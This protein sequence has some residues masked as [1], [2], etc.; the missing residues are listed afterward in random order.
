VGD[1][2]R[3]NLCTTAGMRWLIG[4]GRT[5]S[6]A[7]ALCDVGHDV[8]A[9]PSRIA[10][11]FWR[12]SRREA[13]GHCALAAT[14]MWTFALAV[15]ATP[16]DRT[17]ANG[18]KGADFIQ[19][20]TQGRIVLDREAWR[21]SDPRGLYERQVALVPASAAD[22][23]LPV[24]PPQASV[25]FQPFAAVPYLWAA[26]LWAGIVI[27]VYAGVVWRASKALRRHMADNRLVLIG[28]TAFSPF[29]SLVLHGQTTPFP[30]C[31]FFGAWLALEARRPFIAGLCLSLLSVK[32]QFGLLLPVLAVTGRNG[33]LIASG[34]SM[35]IVL[36]GVMTAWVLGI[37][38]LLKY[39]SV[40]KQ[41]RTYGSLLEPNP[42][43]THSLATLTKLLPSPLSDGLWVVLVAVLA[44]V[45]WWIWRSEGATRV[46]V[47]ALIVI[48]VLA[49]P[50]LFAYDATVLALPIIW[51]CEWTVVHHSE[52]SDRVG[53]LTYGLCFFL[54]VP[55][56]V[57]I[58]V[59]ISVVFIVWLLIELTRACRTPPLHV[60]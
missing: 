11:P 60:S 19:L 35:G 3:H 41:F 10:P 15:Y 34:A 22:R 50:H 5:T 26:A 36:Q 20:Y 16:G 58:G 29:W 46:K 57:L 59:Q 53:A 30:L 48:A 27:A 49:N 13:Y 9:P 6:G 43:Q 55:T 52:R 44:A 24:Y 8:A 47:G 45:L 33:L 31:G 2:P 56:A 42:W 28:A 32:P 17:R 12:I 38:P 7:L 21:L 18:L 25:L 4:L 51:L 23:Y 1:P 14:L 39:V 54:L 40:V 37:E